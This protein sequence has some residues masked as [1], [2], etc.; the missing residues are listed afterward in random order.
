MGPSRAQV[1]ALLNELPEHSRG[2]S[3]IAAST[4]MRKSEVAGIEHAHVDLKRATFF[5][6]PE[7]AKKILDEALAWSEAIE[8]AKNAD[9][10]YQVFFVG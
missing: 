8:A 4:G 5:V 7:N 2:M 6:P 3:I 10:K 1:I 9:R